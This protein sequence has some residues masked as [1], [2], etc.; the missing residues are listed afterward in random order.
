VRRRA[1][2]VSEVA[3]LVRS[4]RGYAPLVG[5]GRAYPDCAAE[6]ILDLAAALEAVCGLR[7][8]VSV[9]DVD[10]YGVPIQL[11]AD[12]NVVKPTKRWSRRGASRG[13]W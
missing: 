9:R 13:G 10:E 7:K 3:D 11:D 2:S 4:A 5:S 8:P 12:G 1:P 6:M